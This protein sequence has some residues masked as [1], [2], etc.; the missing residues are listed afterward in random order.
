MQFH[1]PSD[2]HAPV[3]PPAVPEDEPDEEPVEDG[4]DAGA[5]EG[6]ELGVEEA[7]VLVAFGIV[8]A[9]TTDEARVVG[10]APEPDANPV[11]DEVAMEEEATFGALPSDEDPALVA[12]LG[13]TPAG[14][15]TAEAVLGAE[16]E[17]GVAEEA[18][19]DA[20]EGAE[21]ADPDVVLPLEPEVLLPLV[22]PL[23]LPELPEVA[24]EP[25]MGQQ[26]VPY[27]V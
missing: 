2:V 12:A 24:S 15:L 16:A 9:A 26:L 13:A 27:V 19:P 14:E 6:A 8:V 17:A 10:A 5:S 1:I 22:L 7:T 20:A 3:R 4:A 25:P 11:A 23:L 18:E 21:P